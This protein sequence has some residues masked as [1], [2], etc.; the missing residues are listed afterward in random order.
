MLT[1]QSRKMTIT[2]CNDVGDN[3]GDNA[4]DWPLP[5]EL[6]RAIAIRSSCEAIGVMACVCKSTSALSPFTDTCLVDWGLQWWSGCELFASFGLPDRFRHLGRAP[7]TPTIASMGLEYR[8]RTILESTN[9]H[10]HLSRIVEAFQPNPNMSIVVAAA[11]GNADLVTILRDIVPSNW[12]DN[13]ALTMACML[14]YVDVVRLLLSAAENA[15]YANGR[16][17]SIAANNG[18]TEIARLLLSSPSNT[19]RV[20][21]GIALAIASDNGDADM[22]RL[23]LSYMTGSKTLD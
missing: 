18:N 10:R 1:H 21:C 20:D 6:T 12:D 5:I 14:D 23:L 2:S 8:F 16:A 22:V 19:A 13:I 9:A 4:G 11:C 17:L 7:T 15:A 3:A